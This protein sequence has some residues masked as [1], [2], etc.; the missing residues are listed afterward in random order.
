[1]NLFNYDTRGNTRRFLTWCLR[2]AMIIAVVMLGSIEC[3]EADLQPA[4]SSGDLQ[5]VTAWIA[6]ETS[7]YHQP[8]CWKQSYGRGV[9]KP[10]HCKTGEAEDAAL[11]YTPC[12]PGFKGVGPVCWQSCASGFRDDGA[13]C[14]KPKPYGRG[15]GYPWKF[16]DKAFSLNGARARCA[17]A[18]PQG[19]EKSGEIIYP[20]C[21][22]GFH[23]AGCCI[24]S[25]NCPKGQTDIG[26]SCAKKSYGRGA[27]KP[28][29]TCPTGKDKDAWLC[30]T[31][32]KSGFY[33]VGPVCWQHCT[34]GRVDCGAGCSTS[35]K[36]CVT[37]TA[38]MVYSP[39]LA[40][41]QTAALIV[42]AGTSSAATTA[43]SAAKAAS[44]YDKIKKLWKET[45]TARELIKDAK[46][47]G[48]AGYE[49]YNTTSLWLTEFVGDFE[50][51]TTKRVVSELERH[52]KGDTLLWVKQQYAM[53]HLTL[54]LKADGIDTAE[55]VLTAVSAFDP[56]GLSGVIDAYANPKCAGAENFPTVALLPP[57]GPPPPAPPLAQGL[58][59]L[60]TY[61]SGKCLDVEG[62]NVKNGANVYQ[63][64]CTNGNNQKWNLVSKGGDVYTL[65]ALH[66]GRCLDVAGARNDN[67]ADVLQWDCHGKDNQA[68]Q[69]TRGADGSYRLT[70]RHSGKCL[71]VSGAS[72]NNG[73][74]VLQWDCHSGNNQKWKI[75]ATSPAPPPLA[76]G[77]YTLAA[78]HSGKCLDV[79][80]ANPN[81]G[82]N[83]LQR[84]CHGKDNQ[85]WQI[86]KEGDGSYRLT[87]RH[88]GKCL[89]V[90]GAS[91][92]NGAN[93]L[94]W[95]CHGKDNQKWQIT[96]EGDGSYRLTARHSGRCLDVSGANPNDGANVQQWDCHGKDNQKW[97]INKTD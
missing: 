16:G 26:V 30:Y 66:S 35:K 41:A 53:N 69:I 90:S 88:S 80:G 50:H 40:A 51:M 17:K 96:K 73:A 22:E 65:A 12:Q 86:T 1:M 72:L 42:S 34:S 49:T 33:G 64:D 21:K 47:A 95:K 87:A 61:H 18:H 10:M 74:D 2:S 62:T 81:D 8:Y 46:R 48:S 75:S 15:V 79:S 58:Y 43:A 28:L 68:W 92:N 11:C 13:F 45:A 31:Q 77:P 60:T 6:N 55:S 52:F 59:T 29:S 82:A 4:L 20:K 39:I 24:C 44:K 57:Y 94:Q 38:K 76:D 5:N 63:W 23:P 32:C 9:G 37:D 70:A 91:G 54:M 85:K 67:G 56:S 25:P 89:D 3:A 7:H 27:G 83:V 71:D 78:R 36:S 19:C 97:N 84:K 93:V 14:A